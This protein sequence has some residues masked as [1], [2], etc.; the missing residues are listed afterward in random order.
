MKSICIFAHFNKNNTLEEYIIDYLNA[1]KELVDEVIFVSSS[2][3][4]TEKE[5]ILNK[6]VGKIIIK[7][8]QGYDFGSWKE[9]LFFIK[10]NYIN[11]PNEIILCND[12]CYISKNSFKK[13]ISY[14]QNKKKYDFWGITRNYSF[15]LHIQT[16]FISLNSRPI[17]D[18]KFWDL[19]DSWEHKNRKIN[20]ILKYEIGLSKFL[21]NQKYKMGSYIKLS[22]Y[23]LS[24]LSLKYK[25]IFINQYL[26]NAIKYLLMKNL[27]KNKNNT[28]LEKVEKL[29]TNLFLKKRSFQDII[30]LLNIMLDPLNVN[31]VFLDLRDTIKID[32]PFLKVSR[33]KEILEKE[34]FNKLEKLCI[35]KGFNY[36]NILEHQKNMSKS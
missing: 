30:K 7:E 23:R 17:N 25:L 36:K 4:D 2:E 5:I 26:G 8:N 28:N 35:K 18:K 15:G 32:S 27:I 29:K 3:I 6:I 10:N 12:S 34:G 13:T 11:L 16:Y 19:V 33:V 9:G 21:I 31:L 1:I 22:F 24:I 20:Y 14:M